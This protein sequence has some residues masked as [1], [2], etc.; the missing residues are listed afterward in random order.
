VAGVALRCR[1]AQRRPAA[2]SIQQ[3]EAMPFAIFMPGPFEITIIG[4]IAVLLFGNRLPGLARSFGAA[5]PSFRKGLCDITEEVSEVSDE[6]SSAIHGT[7][8]KTSAK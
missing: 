8:E 3:E 2:F 1:S 4:I 7:K 6:F 5:I